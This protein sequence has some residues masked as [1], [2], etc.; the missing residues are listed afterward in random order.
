MSVLEKWEACGH[1]EERELPLMAA[2]ALSRIAAAFICF[3]RKRTCQQEWL[4]RIL[5]CFHAQ[6]FFSTADTSKSKSS[7]AEESS[8]DS[9]ATTM[10]L[11]QAPKQ[12]RVHRDFVG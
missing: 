5:Q 2:L 12:R 10:V 11:W 3:V 8:W 6:P 9:L 4:T 1:Q 7:E